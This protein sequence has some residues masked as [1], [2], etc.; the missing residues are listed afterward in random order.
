MNGIPYCLC[1]INLNDMA[2]TPALQ[3]QSLYSGKARSSVGG[4]E[5]A[6]L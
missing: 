6:K 5:K 4:M 2:T 3:E 1:L